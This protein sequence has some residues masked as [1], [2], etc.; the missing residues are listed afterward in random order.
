[1]F[2]LHRSHA[3][4]LELFVKVVKSIKKS[5]A[6]QSETQETDIGNVLCT[7][8]LFPYVRS[9]K[10]VDFHGISKYL[11]D[12]HDCVHLGQKFQRIAKQHSNPKEGILL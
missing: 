3:E 12:F 10:L 1:M 5:L 6:K 7:G 4:K 9:S 2:L 8:P 11:R